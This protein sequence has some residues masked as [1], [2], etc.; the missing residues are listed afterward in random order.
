M[1]KDASLFKNNGWKK[2]LP[3]GRAIAAAALSFHPGNRAILLCSERQRCRYR[4]PRIGIN[5]SKTLRVIAFVSMSA[6][7][8]ALGIRNTTMWRCRRL[9]V[10]RVTITSPLLDSW[11]SRSCC[12]IRPRQIRTRRR[13]RRR[14]RARCLVRAGPSRSIL[15]ES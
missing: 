4:R 14:R 13:S 7:F 8:R 3:H 1:S 12:G 5:S 2:F 11:S 15:P 9:V 10:R 6:K